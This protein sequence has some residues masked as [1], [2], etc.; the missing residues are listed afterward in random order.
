MDLELNSNINNDMYIY[1]NSS[2][3]F[4]NNFANQ[5]S[6]KF[7]I[8][9]S[10]DINIF[11]KNKNTIYALDQN[12]PLEKNTKNHT[13]GQLALCEG[14]LL[15]ELAEF[16][17]SKKVGKICQIKLNDYTKL[18]DNTFE[19]IIEFVSFFSAK[20]IF[21]SNYPCSPPK[22]VYFSG[23]KPKNIFDDEGNALIESIKNNNWTPSIWFSKLV[24]SIELLISSCINNE[25]NNNYMSNCENKN[26]NRSLTNF[27]MKKK[28]QKYGKRKWNVYLDECND[29]YSKEFLIL[30]ELEKNLKQLKIK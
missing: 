11:A 17:R 29:Y 15:N 9:N 5:N 12:H 4:N 3:Y 10:P 23:L 2:N 19:I 16:K 22:I 14:R 25:K 27:F 30:P 24:Y 1:D 6:D 7:G 28:M 8:Y 26:C 13:S 18:E 20:F 21:D